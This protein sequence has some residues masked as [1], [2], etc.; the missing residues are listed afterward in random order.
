M[1]TEMKHEDMMHAHKGPHMHEGH[2]HRP[3]QNNWK[4]PVSLGIFLLTASLSLAVLL[5]TALNLVGVIAEAVHPAA[6]QG[7]S[8][9]ELQQ[10]RLVSSLQST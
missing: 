1:D 10:Q 7:M 4:S 3:W 8:Q 5:Y 9:Q 6:S 2:H